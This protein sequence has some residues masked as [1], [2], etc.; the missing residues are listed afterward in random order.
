MFVADQANP[1]ADWTV[2]KVAEKI[3]G[4]TW[5]CDSL[6]MSVNGDKVIKAK[7]VNGEWVV[8]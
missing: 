3:D 7:E 6:M 2:K 8:E 1:D 4:V 5:N